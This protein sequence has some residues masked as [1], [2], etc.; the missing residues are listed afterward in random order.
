MRTVEAHPKGRSAMLRPVA[1]ILLALAAGALPLHAQR[2]T[3]RFIPIGQSPGISGVTSAIGTIEAA[4]TVAMTLRIAAEAGPVTV[5]YTA[6]TSIWLDRSEQRQSAGVGGPAD[7]V[8]GRRVE[9]KFVDAERREVAD[10][11][12]VAVPAGTG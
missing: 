10:W 2:Q 4:D 12:K 8:A 1:F 7:L 3:E 5:R 11:I 9:V 6:A